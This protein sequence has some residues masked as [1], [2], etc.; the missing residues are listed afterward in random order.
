LVSELFSTL[1][2][3]PHPVSTA[4]QS[5]DNISLFRILRIVYFLSEC[6]ITLF[7]P[8]DKAFLWLNS[9]KIASWL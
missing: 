3:S 8:H 4:A 2:Y 5:N 6:K 7:L 9:I 1:L